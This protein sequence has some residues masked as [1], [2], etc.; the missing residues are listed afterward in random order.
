MNIAA[1]RQTFDVTRRNKRLMRILAAFLLTVF[2]EHGQWIALIV[3]AYH[4]GGVSVAG[5]VAV[6]QLVPA[7][8][9]APLLE[10]QFARHGVARFVAAANAV[11]ALSLVG[12]GAA[13]LAGVAPAGVYAFAIV[14]AIANSIARAQQNVLTTLVVTRADELTA[15]NVATGWN[16]AFA[17]L[18]GPL[19]A[20]ILMTIDGPGLACIVSGG[21]FALAAPLVLITHE[22]DEEE[23]TEREEGGLRELVAAAR[24][25]G[26]E[27]TTRALVAFPA[28]AAAVEGAVDLLFVILAVQ[29]LALGEG[30][31]G[32]LS[33]AFGLGGLA[34]SV[35][36]VALVGRKMGLPLAASTLLGGLALAALALV[37]TTAV[38]VVL[39]VAVGSALAIQAVAATTLLQRSTPLDVLACVFSLIESTRDLGMAVGAIIV[40]VLVSLAGRSAAFIGVGALAP[41]AVLLLARQIRSVDEHASIPIVEMAALRAVAIFAPLPAV[42]LETLARESDYVQLGPGEQVIHQGDSGDAF[43][44]ITDGEVSIARDGSEIRRMKRGEGFGEIAL[45]HSVPRTTTVTTT[46]ATTLLRIASEPFLTAL[47][48]NTAVTATAERIAERH[49][50]AAAP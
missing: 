24:A 27:P 34:G 30:G 32:Y 44:A 50:G 46:A 26:T 47:G 48:A 5:L 41:L 1:L 4:R 17:T 3:Y 14:F 37:S 9:I 20:G 43:Y 2:A 33:A 45:L 7:T 22:R 28:A 12:C 21:L 36:A 40:P 23:Q 42:P 35:L 49:L 39:L 15:A 11:G 25:I 8:F 16:K 13:I 6:I 18:G 19:L 38:A 29:V 31:A 10:V